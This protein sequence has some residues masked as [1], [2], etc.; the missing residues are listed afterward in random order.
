MALVVSRRDCRMAVQSGA[1]PLS[2]LRQ[3]GLDAPY[4]GRPGSCGAAD[5]F[6]LR[7]AHRQVRPWV[8][9]PMPFY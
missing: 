3:V 4:A 1:I 7:L 9:G 5:P 8:L 2:L 6:P